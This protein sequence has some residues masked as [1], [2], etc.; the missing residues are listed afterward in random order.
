MK[1]NPLRHISLKKI[2]L[3]F[4]TL[5]FC[6]GVLRHQNDYT[7][8]AIGLGLFVWLLSHIVRSYAV[9]KWAI[10]SNRAL[11]SLKDEI[12]SYVDTV[13]IP[14]VLTDKRQ[15]IRWNNPAFVGLVKK[16]ASSHKL[17]NVIKDFNKPSKDKSVIHGGTKYIKEVFEYKE[18]R[19]T[20]YLYR[21]IDVKNDVPA[22]SIYQNYL[23]VIAVILIDN[24]SELTSSRETLS[25]AEV[26]Y[27]IEKM[28]YEF[29]KPINGF[30]KKTSRDKYVLVFERR[31]LA[32]LIQS[33]FE[34]LDRIS[35][36]NVDGAKP[37]IS[38][39]IGIGN[40]LRDSYASAQKSLDLAIGRG[41]NQ[42]VI[43]RKDKFSF[44]GGPKG[45]I[46]RSSKVKS[47]M[48][49][50]ALRNLIEQCDKV[51]IMGHTTPDF[52]SLGSAMGVA[53]C[54][55]FIGKPTYIV[56][57][58]PTASLDEYIDKVKSHEE[59]NGKIISATES[60]S[61]VT[62]S[63]MVVIVD[64]Q[65]ETLV[66][67]PELLRLSET[68]VVIDHHL[69]GTNNISDAILYYHEPFASSTAELV[70]EIIQYFDDAIKLLPVEA[71][72][73]LSGISVDT[74]SFSFKTGVRTFE[75]ASYLRK[76][77]ADTTT[78][79]RYFKND[80]E[81]VIARAEVIKSCEKIDEHIAIGFCPRGVKSPQLVAAQSADTL[82][83]INGIS[84]AFVFSSQDD[85][86]LISGRSIDG[87]N[88]QLILERIGGG[89]HSTIA[90]A[91]LT[92]VT[93][94]EAKAMLIKAI[95]K[96]K[97]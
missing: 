62:S 34:I 38:I 30:L 32:G 36:I 43:R 85:D 24:Y 40:S 87:Q 91:R 66:A 96:D 60:M 1:R 19:R 5:I 80:Y 35:N 53:A 65:L 79:K 7:L 92:G 17:T 73:L 89:G 26:T 58:P 25:R 27:S 61:L 52:D 15:I 41:G 54:S 69:K 57:E 37:T 71:E 48:L 12:S 16:D 29:A 50:H 82:V 84:T 33:K 94:D 74:K 59:Y 2:V 44:Y 46:I 42:A 9:E 64:T 8:Y 39:A 97:K 67:S 45:S 76:F 78:I 6:V 51:F 28:L 23:G 70:T 21:M 47:R 55:R 75:A 3:F 83:S 56:L 77:G 10:I 13:N 72:A 49:S 31:Y 11:I 86:I 20:Y 88:V 95:D 90:G 93:Y 22:S 14:M 63:S 4:L 18:K 81:T 68:T